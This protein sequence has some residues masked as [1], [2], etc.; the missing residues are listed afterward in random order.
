MIDT[1]GLTDTTFT[2]TTL[3]KLTKYYWR[4]KAVNVGGE[5]NWSEEWNFKTL[6]KPITVTLLLPIDNV[7]NQPL[8]IKFLWSKSEDKLG[9]IK[10][11]ETSNNPAHT[12][13]FYKSVMRKGKSLTS[14]SNY[15]FQLTKGY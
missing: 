12:E 13:Q 6:G 15:W 1:S 11:R 2:L 10:S 3:S 14:V 7:V 5:S 8:E 4:V 9:I